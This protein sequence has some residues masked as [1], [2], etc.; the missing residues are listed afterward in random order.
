MAVAIVPGRRS[1]AAAVAGLL[2]VAVAGMKLSTAF[3]VPAALITIAL[4]D[5]DRARVAVIG[6]A[7]WGVA[8]LVLLAAIPHER[9]WTIDSAILNGLVTPGR[10]VR[11]CRCRGV[12]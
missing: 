12:L 5:R 1:V 8:Y 7:G 2:L 3:L 9:Y 10:A 11:A 4:I 6:A